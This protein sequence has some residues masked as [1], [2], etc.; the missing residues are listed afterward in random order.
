MGFPSG[1]AVSSIHVDLDEYSL[2]IASFAA[3]LLL[4]GLWGRCFTQL[5]GYE[6]PT[7]RLSTMWQLGL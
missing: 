6:S 4:V 7:I 3:P 5:Q 1:V 2:L